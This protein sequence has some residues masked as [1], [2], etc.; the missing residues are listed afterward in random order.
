MLLKR[1]MYPAHHTNPRCGQDSGPGHWSPRD[2]VRRMPQ[3]S[4][5]FMTYGHDL[6][7]HDATK[8]HLRTDAPSAPHLA[9]HALAARG[10][11]RGK[12]GAS[13]TSPDRGGARGGRNAPFA[14]RHVDTHPLQITP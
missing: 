3:W 7:E 4:P 13:L 11:A 8:H 1:V 5:L 10:I 9:E 6:R 2:T 14:P 12:L